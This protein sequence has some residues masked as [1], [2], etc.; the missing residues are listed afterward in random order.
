MKCYVWKKHFREGLI[1]SVTKPK[2]WQ[3][4]FQ[5][6]RS[7]KWPLSSQTEAGWRSRG[8][9]QWARLRPFTCAL[10]VGQGADILPAFLLRVLERRGV[11]RI[12]CGVHPGDSHG[13]GSAPAPCSLPAYVLSAEPMHSASL[14][15]YV[16][17][18]SVI[19][20]V[21][22]PSKHRIY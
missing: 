5:G 22:F 6:M 10:P 18:S 14:L 3:D 21:F 8:W 12:E 15:G 20:G 16:Q 4:R 7:L 19:P 17:T 1:K 2:P 9:L 13:V 11:N